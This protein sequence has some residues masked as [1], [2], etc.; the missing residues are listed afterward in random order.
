M[1]FTLKLCIDYCCLG[2]LRDLIG[3]VLPFFLLVSGCWFVSWF[4]CVSIMI[5]SG[6]NIVSSYLILFIT[7][8][9][10]SNNVAM[11]LN[12]PYCGMMPCY[13]YAKWYRKDQLMF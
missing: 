13:Y 4:F 9:L 10:V 1:F 11:E 3:G 5:L 8:K 6:W 2:V 12:Y 7:I